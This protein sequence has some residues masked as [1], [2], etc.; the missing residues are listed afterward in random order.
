[1]TFDIPFAK[2]SITSKEVEYAT[3]AA[4]NGWGGGVMSI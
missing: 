3:D 2:P 4:A 1:M